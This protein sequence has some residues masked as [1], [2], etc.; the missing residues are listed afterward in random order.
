[1]VTVVEVVMEEMEPVKVVIV[2][3][4]PATMVIVVEPPR[5]PLVP[6]ATMVIVVG[7]WEVSPSAAVSRR[8]ACGAERDASGQHSHGSYSCCDPSDLHRS[9]LLSAITP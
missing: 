6:R 5:V 3:E 1:M 7:A 2:V 4:R 9:S 8:H